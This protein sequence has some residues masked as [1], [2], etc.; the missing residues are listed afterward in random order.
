MRPHIL[1][2]PAVARWI[3]NV[4]TAAEHRHDR[5]PRRERALER[6]RVDAVGSAGDD[7]C[8]QSAELIAKLLCLQQ[9]VGRGTSCPD[10]GNDGFG[11]D[12]RDG[13]LIV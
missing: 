10:H 1:K 9:P 8:P 4:H 6:H 13:S 3:R 2:K 12:G 11:V 7:D 5:M